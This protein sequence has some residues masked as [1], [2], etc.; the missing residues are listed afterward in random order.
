MRT[1]SLFLVIHLFLFLVIPLFLRSKIFGF[2]HYR[3]FTE[4]LGVYYVGYAGRSWGVYFLSP[5]LALHVMVCA[6]LCRWED[7]RPRCGPASVHSIIG[8][9]IPPP[10]GRAR[11]CAA[12]CRWRGSTAKLRSG[13]ADH[14]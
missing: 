4:Y 3:N 11:V 1:P 12:L 5:L 8:T 10:G 13:S 14:T 9:Y 2:I 6:A 7:R